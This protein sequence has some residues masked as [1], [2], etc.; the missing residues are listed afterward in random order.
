MLGQSCVTSGVFSK[1][2]DNCVGLTSRREGK[3]WDLCVCVCV[4]V[5]VCNTDRPMGCNQS[6]T[7]TFKVSR[8]HLKY[9]IYLYQ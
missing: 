1:Q 7:W 3:L 4:R 2:F 8:G 6:Q 9:R 5:H